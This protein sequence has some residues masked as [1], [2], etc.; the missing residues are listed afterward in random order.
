MAAQK[1]SHKE[2][3]DQEWRDL[4]FKAVKDSC[5]DAADIA[6]YISQEEAVERL[7]EVRA[8][9]ELLMMALLRKAGG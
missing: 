8:A 1:L 9:L 6:D 4:T 5:S 7:S 3:R 2:C